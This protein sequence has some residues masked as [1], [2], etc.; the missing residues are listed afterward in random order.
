VLAETEY[1]SYLLRLWQATSAGKLVWRASLEAPHTG[2]RHGFASLEQLFAFL[3]EQAAGTAE[4]GAVFDSAGDQ[5][6]DDRS[7]NIQIGGTK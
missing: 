3:M 4:P 7:T 1:K 2:L 5:A 6:D